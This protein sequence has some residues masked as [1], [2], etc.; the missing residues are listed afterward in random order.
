MADPM[1]RKAPL[2]GFG[3]LLAA[4]AGACCR[5]Q[6]EPAAP[7][8]ATPPPPPA[9]PPPPPA[10]APDVPKEA[11]GPVPVVRFTEGLST[12]ESVL[13]DA[14]N[15]RYLVSNI[16][17]KPLDVDNNGYVSEL[18][19]EGKLV[20]DKFI[21]GGTGTTKLN[22]P[23][24]LALVAGVLY[25]AD[26]DVVR[27]FDAK[28]GAPKGD[29]PI[30]GA[31]FL[32]DVAAAP[33]GK[34]Y[35]SDSGM[36]ASFGPTGTDAIWVIEKDKPK[37]LA[38][39]KEL[40]GPNGVIPVDKGVITVT[41][42]GTEAYRLDD[43][44]KKLETTQLPAGGLDGIVA[45]G[46]SLLITSWKASTIFRGK[47]GGTFTPVLEKLSAPADIGFDTKRSRVLVPRFQDNTV[48]VYEIK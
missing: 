42:N 43:K 46:D 18:S 11:Q 6:P 17:G 24:G 28:T 36:D 41:F 19:P 4:G 27:K 20:K 30:K 33:D 8:A 23:K 7:V 2:L 40:G 47:L 39:Y 3:L 48:E 45:V 35:V 16:N 37:P 13:Y 5:A 44:G 9:P 1:M 25:V 38:K 31:T 15:D 12:P 14:E 32:N 22:A 34:I 26:I 10:A 29:I 21:A